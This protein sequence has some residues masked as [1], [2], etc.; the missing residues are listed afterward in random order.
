MNTIGLA[1]RL[2]SDP[3]TKEVGSEG[4]KKTSFRIAVQGF[5][6]ASFF[7][8]ECWGKTAEN[9]AKYCGKGTFVALSGRLEQDTWQS[10]EGQN[11][12]K[13]FVVAENVTFGPKVEG[14]PEAGDEPAA[15]S[16]GGGDD[17][18]LF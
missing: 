17:E 9:V 4:K 12:E 2:A 6:K 11:R 13:V 5:K 8:V 3:E 1:G 14:S 15:S 10:D 16:S 7:T 18:A